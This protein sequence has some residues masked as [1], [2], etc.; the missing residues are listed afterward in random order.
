MKNNIIAVAGATGDLGGRIVSA[1]LNKGAEVRAIVRPTSDSQ[2]IRQL[3]TLG[4]EV[5]KVSTWTLA[6]LSKAC[7]GACC[8]VSALA[9]LRDVIIDAQKLLVDGAIA[10]GVP[11]FIPSD[12]SLD[13]TK[14]SDGENRN[15]DLRREFHQHLDSTSISSTTIFNGAFADLL[16]DKMPVILFKQKLVLYWGNADNRWDFTTMDDTA[17][18]TAN[19]ALDSSTPR[20]LRIAGDQISPREIRAAV[21]QV[22]GEKFKLIRTGGQKLLGI[23]IKIARTFSPSKDD[24]Y[25]AWQGM[26]YMHNMIDKR[27]KIEKLDNDRYPG[28]HWT[29]VKELLVE[30]LDSVTNNS[31]YQAAS[32]PV[33]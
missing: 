29:R 30:H 10:A 32:R 4:V 11:R 13:F 2:K 9:G 14:F 21:S 31:A 25:P 23:I 12:Y 22:T 19:A 18:Y 7:N 24:L 15:L 33:S 16:L 26:Q 17:T 27:A 8:V 1:L 6:E 28:M 20:Y 5:Y 3:E